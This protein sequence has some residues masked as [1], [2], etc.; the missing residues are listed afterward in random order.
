[1]KPAALGAG[2]MEVVAMTPPPDRKEG[3]IV[4]EGGAAVAEL[5]RLLREEAKVL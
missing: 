5:V 4:G 3:K 2:R 1:M